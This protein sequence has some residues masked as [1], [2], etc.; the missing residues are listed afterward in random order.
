MFSQK[1]KHPKFQ[2]LKQ[3]FVPF[4]EVLHFP[5]HSKIMKVKMKSE[6][7][8]WKVKIFYLVEKHIAP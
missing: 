8:K 5:S 1:Q 3:L 6:N 7:E 4:T 2:I